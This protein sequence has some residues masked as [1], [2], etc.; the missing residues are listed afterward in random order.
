M[1]RLPQSLASSPLA[2]QLYSLMASTSERKYNNVYSRALELR[3]S[4]SQPDFF[5]TSLGA[6]LGLL[7]D[8][9]LE[10]FR[11]RTF[12]LLSKA[13]TSLTLSLAQMY[14]GLPAD[15]VLAAAERGGW[16]YDS[17]AQILSPVQNATVGKTSNEFAPPS[18]LTSF[19][20]VADSVA[21]LE[22]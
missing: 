2:K 21:K 10:A 9:F 20:F 11:T 1:T 16:Q 14:L 6:L 4:V 13:Y 7:I 18:S 3:N 17:S 15:A 19:H 5:D 12:N 8:S 22:T